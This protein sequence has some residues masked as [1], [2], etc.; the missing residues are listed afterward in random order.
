MLFFFSTG[1]FTIHPSFFH[2]HTPTSSKPAL[3]HPPLPNG[4]LDILCSVLDFRG[5]EEPK[6]QVQGR[7]WGAFVL[8]S[9][10]GDEGEGPGQEPVAARPPPHSTAMMFVWARSGHERNG[11]RRVSVPFQDFS[12]L[13]TRRAHFCT[14]EEVVYPSLFIFLEQQ[15]HFPTP[16]LPPPPCPP[17]LKRRRRRRRIGL[18]LWQFLKAL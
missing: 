10:Q 14:G 17:V 2:A 4:S 13:P 3:G 5:K 15:G 12:F 16:H 18:F 11:A 6:K 8:Q 7:T 1:H 9:G